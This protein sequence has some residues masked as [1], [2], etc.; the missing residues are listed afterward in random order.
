MKTKLKSFWQYLFNV[1]NKPK[2]HTLE[3]SGPERRLSPRIR[4][5]LG[6]QMWIECLSPSAE[7]LRLPIDNISYSGVGI[8]RQDCP[9]EFQQHS[10]LKGNLVTTSL[11]V[12]IEFKV[13]RIQQNI[14]GCE[15]IHPPVQ[16]TN[17]IANQFN[18]EM[19]AL[20]VIQINPQIL[21]ENKDGQPWWFKNESGDEIFL[22]E[23]KENTIVRFSITFGNDYLE[24]NTQQGLRHAQLEQDDRGNHIKGATLMH[25][26][27]EV[28][29]D[30]KI[31]ALR[32]VSHVTFLPKRQMSLIYKLLN[33]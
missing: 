7:A 4:L 24:W 3:F 6:Q 13:I 18:L 30:I 31:H 21:G 17:L 25:F 11:S 26:S 32:F 16:I 10:I 23:S 27:S 8:N 2:Q 22:I 20:K 19:S 33:S 29:Q 1:Q 14:I 15:F 5:T 12:P 28:S 9:I